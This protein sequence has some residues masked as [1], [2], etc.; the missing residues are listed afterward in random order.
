MKLFSHKLVLSCLTFV[1][2]IAAT[3]SVEG[4]ATVSWSA[5]DT[6]GLALA[7]GTLI[8]EGSGL[9]QIGKFDIPDLTIA[10]NKTDLIYLAS[11]FTSFGFGVVGDGATGYDGAFSISSANSGATF[12]GQQI[13]LWA[14]YPN[15][16]S[17]TPTQEGIFY[18]TLANWKFPTDTDT[19]S[20][21]LDLEEVN[22][23]VVGT[24]NGAPN[25]WATVTTKLEVIPEPST[26][27][28]VMVGLGSVC[29]FIRRRN[30]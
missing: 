3:I 10:A 4:A 9:L 19:G 20:T 13:Y 25:G 12:A 14:L 28:L 2:L 11:H 27:T 18:S 23:A 16:G 5:V 30:K 21:S 7:D 6:N 26:T 17:G 22:T 15:P 1:G 8:P 24:L 29:L